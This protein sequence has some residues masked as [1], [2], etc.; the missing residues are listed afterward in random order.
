M[1][2][3]GN[4]T[5]FNQN[6]HFNNL[7]EHVFCFC[8]FSCLLAICRAR[9]IVCDASISRT[10]QTVLK[11]VPTACKVPTASSSSTPRPTTSAIPAMPTA[12]KGKSRRDKDKSERRALTLVTPQDVRTLQL[13]F[14]K[15]KLSQMCKR[16]MKANGSGEKKNGV[17]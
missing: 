12:P 6:M 11:S 10:A 7:L 9:S 17:K 14:P 1:Q 13:F 4:W 8:F 2:P 16:L 3:I 15:S 5:F